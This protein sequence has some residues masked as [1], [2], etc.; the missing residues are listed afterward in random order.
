[1]NPEWEEG[2]ENVF[3]DLGFPETESGSMRR[4]GKGWKCEKVA[5]FLPL[6]ALCLSLAIPRLFGVPVRFA[7]F[8]ATAIFVR[9]RI[10][11]GRYRYH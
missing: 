1:M 3:K 8:S 10:P 9:S 5:V 6:P 11:D 7:G 4:N 2:S